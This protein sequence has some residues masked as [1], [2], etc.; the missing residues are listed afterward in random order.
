MPF[1]RAILKA[2]ALIGLSLSAATARANAAAPIPSPSRVGGPRLAWKTPLV[3]REERL[4]FLCDEVDEG[5]VCSF[6]A[7]YRI[8]NPSSEPAGGR[9]AF[10]G[11]R[12]ENIVVLVDGRRS[13]LH[14]GDTELRIFELDYLVSPIKTWAD[15]H[16][17]IVTIRYPKSW[18][19]GAARGSL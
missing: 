10:Y 12:A 4:S 18:S 8:E 7:R 9:A 17:L 13:D 3:V 14:A 19:M 1:P 16:R 2:L 15:V 6:E 5:P 11:L